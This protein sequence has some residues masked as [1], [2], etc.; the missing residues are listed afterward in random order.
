MDADE[1]KM[2]VCRMRVQ[3]LVGLSRDELRSCCGIWTTSQVTAV[4]GSTLETMS[5]ILPGTGPL[6]VV[7]IESGKVIGAH[8]Y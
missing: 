7:V 8:A 5:Y 4:R 1:Q 3:A 2:Q 6:L